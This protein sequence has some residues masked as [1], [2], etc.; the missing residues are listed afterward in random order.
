MPNAGSYEGKQL[1]IEK[2]IA[3]MEKRT[4]ITNAAKST[5]AAPDALLI[6]DRDKNVDE[7]RAAGGHAILI[8]RPWN[9]SYEKRNDSY[10]VFVEELKQY[11]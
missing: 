6:D 2:N 4:I 8:P 10:Q 3:A 11:V 9:S 7:F 1:W 5:F